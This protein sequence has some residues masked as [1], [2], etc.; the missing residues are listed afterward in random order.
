MVFAWEE[1]LALSPLQAP[2]GGGAGLA[3]PG[4]VAGGVARLG[5]EGGAARALSWPAHLNIRPDFTQHFPL[6]SMLMFVA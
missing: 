1:A 4:G 6:L 5:G 2:G 3:V